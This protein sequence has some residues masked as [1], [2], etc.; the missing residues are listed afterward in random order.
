[1][2]TIFKIHRPEL[3]KTIVADPYN[4]QMALNTSTSKMVSAGAIMRGLVIG[5]FGVN[6]P[7]DR[8]RGA[9]WFREIVSVFK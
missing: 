5:L 8:A 7:D 6:F 9:V 3:N 2:T 1:M 4:L